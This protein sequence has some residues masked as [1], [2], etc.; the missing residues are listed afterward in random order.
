V[1]IDPR[2]REVQLTGDVRVDS[3]PFH[4]TSD[5]LHVR[6]DARGAVDVDGVGRLAFCPCLGTP[7]AVRF[8][9]ALVAP[10]GDLILRSPTLQ[11][12][13]VPILWLPY[14]WLRSP[15][16]AGLL[17]PEVAYRGADGMFLGGGIHLPWSKGDTQRGLDLRAGGYFEGGAAVDGAL[18]TPSS[19]THV[20]WDHLRGDGLTLEARGG[21]TRDRGG[22]SRATL[23]WDA[24]AIRG[25]RGVRATTELE[26][27]ARPYDR[28][29]G[30]MSLR[31]GGWTFASALRTTSLRGGGV[32]D[33]GM[34]GPIATLRSG[35]AVAGA[36][37]YD[38]TVEA[39][40]LAETGRNVSFGRADAGVTLADR[41]G[42]LGAT[43]AARV[44]GD[45]VA[46]GEDVGASRSGVDGAASARARLGL[47]VARAFASNEPN[48][49]WLHRI[50][51]SAGVGWLGS[52][53]DDLLGVAPGRGAGAVQGNALVADG[54]LASSQGRWGGRIGSE[55]RIAAGVVTSIDGA[56]DARFAARG[57]AALSSDVLALTAEAAR[58]W[59][60]AAWGGA[61]LGRVRIGPAGGV[62]LV[63]LAAERDGL[64]P[65]LARAL[66]DAPLE[67]SGGFLSARGWT[68]GARA[69]V[70]W[71]PWFATT[72]GGDYDAT[73]TLLVSARGGIELRDRCGCF[74]VTATAAHRL[75]RDGVDA[76]VAVDL[77]PRTP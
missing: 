1:E 54:A 52:H 23:A 63:A 27:A 30:E 17:P 75:G 11:L 58:A 22:D 29:A 6:R 47:P 72:G 5:A 21:I 65:I 37:G 8:E 24:D 57:H 15:A 68:L 45:A 36:G 62:H 44:A 77:A 42:P 51:P 35:G 49:P 4:L 39:G 59:T 32:F 3:P 69:R 64:D 7:L 66:T 61:F 38:A 48:D 34:A 53:G 10:P 13:G 26:A 2:T 19:A 12:A 50:E 31:A 41:W 20:G 55:L 70:P 74:K 40:M 56:I 33:V 73:A 16:K 46:D 25:A 9:G 60:G 67:P 28:A 18:T 76:W 71:T 43:A 14:F